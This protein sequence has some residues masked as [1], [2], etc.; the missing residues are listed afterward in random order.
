MRLVAD[1]EQRAALQEQVRLLAGMGARLVGRRVTRIELPDRD[2]ERAVE[3]RREQL[4]AQR[5]VGRDELLAL[6]AADDAHHGVALGEQPERRRAERAGDVAQRLQRRVAHAA[7]HLAEHRHADVGQARRAAPAS[8]PARGAG[9]GSPRRAGAAPG[10]GRGPSPAR[11]RP[12]RRAGRRSPSSGTTLITAAPNSM[13]ASRGTWGTS[14]SPA[15]PAASAAPS[16]TPCW[17][18]ATGCSRS[19]A[20]AGG[21]GDVRELVVDAGDPDA[22]EAALAEGG[23]RRLRAAPRRRRSPARALPAEKACTDPAELPLDVF[24]ASLELNLVTAWITLQAALPHLRRSD[25]RPLDRADDVDRRARQLRAA[26]VRRG[27]G[28]ADRPRARAR[29]EPR[30]PRASASTRWRPAT[31]RR[32]ATC[33]SGGTCPGWYDRLREGVPLGRLGTPRGHGARVSS[34]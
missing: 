23:G 32:R 9:A 16:S 14:W 24:R 13:L 18:A 27:E 6:A 1:L 33:A 7:L 30:R 26:R 25:G 2:L 15:R 20:V 4:E 19:T 34:R 31:C 28:R 22:V 10:P 3:R 21:R 11:R 12:G 5:A 8:V 29:G 17:R